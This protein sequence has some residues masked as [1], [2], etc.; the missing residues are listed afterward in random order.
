M[1]WV[2]VISSQKTLMSKKML[3]PNCKI[4]KTTVV[5]VFLITMEKCKDT[6]HTTKI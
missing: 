5:V 6:M 2:C 1:H 4:N 3:V